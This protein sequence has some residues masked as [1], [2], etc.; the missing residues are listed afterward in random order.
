MKMKN[1]EGVGNTLR[2]V[3]GYVAVIALSTLFYQLVLIRILDI[4]WYPLYTY[5]AIVFAFL[6]AAG[7]GSYLIDKFSLDKTR[8][9]RFLP[10]LGIPLYGTLPLL[11]EQPL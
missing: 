9:M 1:K 7:T 10:F 8:I 4:L 5:A 6:I 11:L 3:Q 2:S